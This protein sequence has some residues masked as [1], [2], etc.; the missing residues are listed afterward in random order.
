MR[1]PARV[2]LAVGVRTPARRVVVVRG[3]RR[4]RPV[5]RRK[6]DAGQRA[7]RQVAVVVSVS[8]VQ[9]RARGQQRH[10]HVAQ[11]HHVRAIGGVAA[12]VAV[13]AVLILDLHHCHGAAVG[14]RQRAHKGQQH[15]PPLR[16]GGE[17]RGAVCAQVRARR[18]ARRGQQVRRQPAEI[19]LAANVRASAQQQ[20]H[21]LAL[22]ELRK[23][24]EVRAAR[25]VVHAT[26][27]AVK[28]PRYVR[29]DCVEPQSRQTRNAVRPRARV[30]A[31]VVQGARLHD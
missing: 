1:Q 16:H 26:L 27:L 31:V 3:V 23:V 10:G 17:V 28:V 20:Q 21:A 4:A 2:E 19:V 24:R 5:A 8:R 29:L 12:R 13:A 18:N 11:R 15:V 14:H 30:R 7:G 6:D 22:H 9:L 25:K